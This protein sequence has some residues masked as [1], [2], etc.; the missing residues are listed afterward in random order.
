LVFIAVKQDNPVSVLLWVSHPSL[1]EGFIDDIGHAAGQTGP[2]T[3]VLR[4]GSRRMGA[5]RAETIEDVLWSAGLS[6]DIIDGGHLRHALAVLLDGEA[7][8]R[9]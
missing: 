8:D 9:G 7:T 2:D 5:W 6:F 4:L 1:Y 3:L